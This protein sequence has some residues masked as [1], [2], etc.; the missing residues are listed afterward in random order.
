MTLIYGIGSNDADYVVNPTVN[1]KRI[2]CPFYKVW[3]NM[4]VRCYSEK[5]LIRCP[6]YKG[7]E[8]DKRWH[9]FMSFKEWMVEQDWVGNQL[10]K[11]LL[12]S[13]NKI[14]SPETCVF[15]S[16]Q[17]NV[18]MTDHKRGRGDLPLGVCFEPDTGKFKAQCHNLGKGQ[19]YLGLY[20][21]PVL[22][23]NAYRK[24]KFEYALDLANVQSDKRISNALI[25]RYSYN[26]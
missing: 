9:S 18:F 1:G 8:V 25:K 2:P 20:D 21:T 3:F 6:S 22:A 13:E 10:D 12:A 11:D 23:Y 19:T 16:R 24:C 4:L 7:C 5:S 14:Y 15:V 26:E 17:V